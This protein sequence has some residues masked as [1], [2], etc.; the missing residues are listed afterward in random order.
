MQKA[1]KVP[2]FQMLYQGAEPSSPTGYRDSVLRRVISALLERWNPQSSAV[3][4]KLEA[5]SFP[6]SKPSLIELC[7]LA[8]S[9]T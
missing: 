5:L 3:K 9:Q 2:G 6:I 8:F 7:H 1:F 4:K